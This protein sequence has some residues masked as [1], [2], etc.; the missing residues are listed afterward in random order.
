MLC[1]VCLWFSIVYDILC[2]I[3]DNA[4]QSTLHI[5]RVVASDF[6]GEYAC[7]MQ[8][9]HAKLN[10]AGILVLKRRRKLNYIY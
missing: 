10:P 7:W 1:H 8:N 2:R 9:K 3:D 5:D 4:L 6:D